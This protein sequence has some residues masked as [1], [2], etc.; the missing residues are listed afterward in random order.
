MPR[1]IMI[2]VD[3]VGIG[4]PD[5]SLN[6]VAASGSAFF[7]LD[8]SGIAPVA[9]DGRQAP[10]DARLGVAGTPQSATGQTTLLSGFN[11]AAEIG[12]HRV[13]FPNAEL[14]RILLRRNVLTSVLESGRRAAFVNCYPVNADFLNG[15]V[16]LDPDGSFKTRGAVPAS[17]LRRI[18]ATT[19]A[20]LA[21][22]QR[23]RDLDDLGREESL[24]H[25][26]TNRRLR[27]EGIDVPERSPA[28]AGR[29]LARIARNLDFTLYEHFLTDRA[30]HAADHDASIEVVKNLD[31]FLSGLLETALADGA[32]VLLT[33]DHGNI[34][35]SS[36][37]SHTTNPVPAT[38]W[39]SHAEERAGS[40]RSL[41]DVHDVIVSVLESDRS[42]G[43]LATPRDFAAAS[44]QDRTMET[45]SGSSRF[46]HEAGTW[47]QKVHR[48]ILAEAI[49]GCMKNRMPFT[50]D[51]R[52]MDFGA[53]TGLVSLALRPL[54]GSLTAVDTSAPM[55]EAL[56]AKA[57]EA[58]LDGVV[59][60]VA[61]VERGG[62]LPGPFDMIV[63]SM[64][65]HHVEDVPRLLKL[66]HAALVPGGWIGIADLDEEDGSFHADRAG[67]H[68]DGFARA[69]LARQAADAGFSSIAFD[70]AHV[71]RREDRGRSYPVFL[72]T[73]RR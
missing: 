64:V 70:D 63:S 36:T 43:N 7:S 13:G 8:R 59:T 69:A 68:H 42:A 6:P 26:F 33:S 9:L 67:V 10:V 57:A 14:R 22:R 55:I 21:A 35:D 50:R 48:R 2:F 4:E 32:T 20:A 15:F 18:S 24:F 12:A 27:E 25:D 34:E 66:F 40:V 37:G 52:A 11:A 72:M 56:R 1:I 45:N 30:G 60:L 58:G 73:A 19:A 23:L 49:A 71:I 16:T 17:V 39:G 3:G 28:E 51:T 47:D 5:P 41:T 62:V 54:V 61:D 44:C 31:G 65:F 53:G 46:D 38:F 29:I